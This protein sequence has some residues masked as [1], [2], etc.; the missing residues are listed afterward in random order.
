MRN[1]LQVGDEIITIGGLCGKIVKLKD[2]SLIIQVGADKVKFE[3]MRWSI[4]K[5]VSSDQAAARK[6]KSGTEEAAPEESKKVMPKKLG[7]K[8]G[9]ETAVPVA[10]QEAADPAPQTE[11]PVIEVPAEDVEVLE[12]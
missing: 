11:E 1:S 9:E 12:K 4:S 8:N 7:K 3:V 10:E 2:E 6:A 5:V